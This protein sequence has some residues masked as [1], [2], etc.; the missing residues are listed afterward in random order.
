MD[1]LFAKNSALISKT[2]TQ[3]P[4]RVCQ[5]LAK[6]FILL[7]DKHSERC[8]K[9][10]TFVFRKTNYSKMSTLSKDKIKKYTL[11]H[12]SFRKIGIALS[13]EKRIGIV[14]VIF[15]RLKTGCQWRELPI[16]H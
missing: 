2:T 5:S 14:S 16:K 12:L 7:Q 3:N 4:N 6:L 9:K 15:Y 11:L 10:N 1:Y 13:E 8:S